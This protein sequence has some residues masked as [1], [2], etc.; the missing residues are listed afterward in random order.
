MAKRKAT[1]VKKAKISKEETSLKNKQAYRARKIKAI[2]AEIE[3]LTDSAKGNLDKFIKEKGRKR[4][5]KL[6]TIINE[7]R[8]AQRKEVKEYK[9]VTKDR[10][11]LTGKKYKPKKDAYQNL[12]GQ[13][14]PKKGILTIGDFL[15]WEYNDA[16]KLI[17]KKGTFHGTS[18]D[19]VN[20]MWIDTDLDKADAFLKD[21][22]KNMESKDVVILK[23]DVNNNNVI[24]QRSK[25]KYKGNSA[26][27]K[28]KK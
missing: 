5:R 25:S 1:P 21:I 16:Y 14:N 26:G 19:K 17:F 3:K 7:K 24:G 4:P 12:G 2:D 6:S 11:K 15:A 27:R 10:E 9:K 8:N 23:L 20:N 18:I 22:F 28:Y 13:T